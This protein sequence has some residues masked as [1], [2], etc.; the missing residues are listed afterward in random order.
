[1]RTLS[2]VTVLLVPLTAVTVLLAGCGSND[3]GQG[4]G[5]GA[6]QATSTGPRS[7]AAEPVPTETTGLPT[8][9]TAQ[10]ATLLAALSA[11]NPSLALVPTSAV[12]DA[13]ALCGALRDGDDATTAVPSTFPDVDLDAG[14]QQAVAAAVTSSF[15]VVVE[16]TASPT[17]SSATAS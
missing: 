4:S 6:G 12:Q 5:N 14:Q 15:C 16:G 10:T 11:I 8:P 3:A 17:S 1:M 13:V 2:R 9:D 7:S